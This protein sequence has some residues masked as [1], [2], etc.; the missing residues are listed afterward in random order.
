MINS[1]ETNTRRIG[2]MSVTPPPDL[3]KEGEKDFINATLAKMQADSDGIDI[4]L[5]MVKKNKLD[6]WNIDVVKLADMYFAKTIELRINNLHVT[7]RVIL[8]ACRLLRIKSDIKKRAEEILEKLGI[9][10]SVAVDMFYRQIIAHKGIPFALT[11]KNDIP[12]R[13]EMSR[14]Q[15]D[16][17]MATGLEQAKQD[18]AY[19]VDEVFDDLEK[20]LLK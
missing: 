19:D 8:F 11:L 16:D 10:R 5:E 14:E 15:F 18:E 6:P 20:D 4:L 12:V 1:T 3:G 9:P 7:S 17:M 13:E 2:T